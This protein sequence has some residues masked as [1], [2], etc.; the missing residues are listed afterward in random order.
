MLRFLGPEPRLSLLRE[1][2]RDRPPERALEHAI[3]LE[4]APPEPLRES[5]T[6][7]R[8]PGAHKADQDE[9]AVQRVRGCQSIRSRYVR[10]A[11]RKS[12]SESPPNFSRAARASSQ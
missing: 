2:L 9:V 7:R 8:L 3:D 11:A 10:C 4:E 1:D 5:G 12:P 6:E